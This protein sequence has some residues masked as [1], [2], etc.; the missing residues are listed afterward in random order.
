MEDPAN[1]QELHKDQGS[2]LIS[3]LEALANLDPSTDANSSTW[4]PT[5]SI[6][7]QL[8]LAP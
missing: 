1:V 2:Q 8:K 7:V 3:L 5:C 4:P 6:A